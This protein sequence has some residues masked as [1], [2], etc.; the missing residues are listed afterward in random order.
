[1][2]RGLEVTEP[3]YLKKADYGKVPQYLSLVKV[4]DDDDDEEEEEEE[5][6]GGGGDDND[7]DDDHD[8]HDVSPQGDQA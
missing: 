7:D 3:D 4:S 8:D 1:V 5:E 6:S 2:P